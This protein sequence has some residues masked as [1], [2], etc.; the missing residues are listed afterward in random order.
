MGVNMRI[1]AEALR[2]FPV[3]EGE[4]FTR[5]LRW[6][7]LV[8]LASLLCACA[9]M[10]APAGDAATVPLAGLAEPG[11]R[12]VV[13]VINANSIAGSHAGMF[14]GGRLYDPSGTYTGKRSEDSAWVGPSLADYVKF[15][16]RDGPDVRLFRFSLAEPEF[17]RIQARIAKAGWSLPLFCAEDVQAILAG[18]GPF[19]TLEANRW[20]SPAGLGLRLEALTPT[21]LV[22]A[23]CD[24]PDQSC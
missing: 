3:G 8:A 18:I 5:C 1:P 22:R 16:L 9:H 23:D 10:P 19:L 6:G 4:R 11:E 2:Q 15:H 24:M 17:A 20:T 21:T 14:A 7:A 13:V 12:E